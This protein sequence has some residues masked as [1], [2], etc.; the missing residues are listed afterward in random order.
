VARK[1][2]QARANVVDEARVIPGKELER[3]ERGAATGRALVLETAAQKLGLLPVAELADRAV[4]DCP[5][6]V[7]RRPG[8]ALDLVLPARAEP[9]ERLFLAALGQV[10]RFGSR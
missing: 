7:V 3:D 5:L 1:L 2:V 10:G 8:E 6:T 4:G 9:G